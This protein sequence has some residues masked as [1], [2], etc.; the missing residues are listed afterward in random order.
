MEN[1][2]RLFVSGCFILFLKGLNPFYVFQLFS[3]CLWIG[4][5]YYYY[6]GCIGFI[7]IVSLFAQ[8]Y[9]QRQVV[10]HDTLRQSPALRVFAKSRD[11]LIVIA[12]VL[13]F[14]AYAHLNMSVIIKNIVICYS[15]INVIVTALLICI[16]AF[17]FLFILLIIVN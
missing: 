13:V 8:I 15:S 2:L 6:A 5:E 3:I 9:Q 1:K 10:S 12:R 16:Y 4:E 11:L 17:L 14:I 7:S